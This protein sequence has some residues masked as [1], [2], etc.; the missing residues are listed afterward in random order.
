MKPFQALVGLLVLA[1]P[2]AHLSAAERMALPPPT[3]KLPIGRMT[4]FWKDASRG[5]PNTPDEQDKRE[6]R[7][8]VWYPAAADASGETAPYWPELKTLAKSMLADSILFGALRTHALAEATPAKDEDRYPVLL[9]SPGM[10]MN[11]VQ[12]TGLVED[13][14]SHGYVVATVDHPYQCRAIALPDGRAVFPARTSAAPPSDAQQAFENYRRLVEIRSADLRFVLDELKRL[15]AGTDDSRFAGRLDF[16]RVGVLGHSLGGVA[17]T[18]ACQ[19][20]PR[21]KS[22]VNLDGHA[23]SLPFLPD[24]LDRGP[25]Q[26]LVELTDVPSPPSDRE[27]QKRGETR[28][29]FER[30]LAAEKQRSDHAMRTVGGGS[31]RV[32]IAGARHQSFSDAVV[33]DPGTVDERLQRIEVI[34][35]CVRAFFDKTLLGKQDTLLDR[36]SSPYSEVTI[37]RFTPAD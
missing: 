13:L 33:I 2:V 8:Y 27:L 17:A 30:R 28:E 11:G 18:E 10:G 35:G 4:Y 26:P 24:A 3:G 22:V 29:Q 32:S 5:E 21:F 36:P 34:R 31:F 16:D 15:D 25:R 37:E 14:V 23:R 9:L 6:V 19:D 7:V 1:A 12:Y 20:D